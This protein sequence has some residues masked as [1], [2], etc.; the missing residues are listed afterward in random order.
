M[1]G[2]QTGSSE[3]LSWVIWLNHKHSCTNWQSVLREYLAVRTNPT[4]AEFFLTVFE[5]E[6]NKTKLSLKYS[7]RSVQTK[8]SVYFVSFSLSISKQRFLF[9]HHLSLFIP[10]SHYVYGLSVRLSAFR[11]FLQIWHK[12]PL[13]LKEDLIRYW[14]SKVTVTSQIRFFKTY[15]N[16]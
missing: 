11:E 9:K 16:V 14:W 8:C 13:G 1:D 5:W 3:L 6:K 2:W 4:K 15:I 10:P 12:L 7:P